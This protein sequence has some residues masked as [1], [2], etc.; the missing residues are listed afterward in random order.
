MCRLDIITGRRP[1]GD[2][3]IMHNSASFVGGDG[4]ERDIYLEPEPDLLRA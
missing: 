1:T 3:S 2:H 4:A